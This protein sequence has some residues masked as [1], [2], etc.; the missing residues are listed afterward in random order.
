MVRNGV[1]GRDRRPIEIGGGNL[2]GGLRPA[3]GLAIP[4][5]QNE[6]GTKPR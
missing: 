6:G 2:G 4:V 5:G 1:N 3:V